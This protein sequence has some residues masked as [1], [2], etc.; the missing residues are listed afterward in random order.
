MKKLWKA[1][2]EVEVFIVSEK[3]PSDFDIA[4]AVEEE[5]RNNGAFES[6]SS[7]HEVSDV[8]FVP[9]IWR[10]GLPY[11]DHDNKTVEQFLSEVKK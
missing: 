7:C 2:A 3:E 1:T 6:I 5:L 10:D 8:K 9:S 11:G 4:D